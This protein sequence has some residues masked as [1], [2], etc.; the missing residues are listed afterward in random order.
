MRLLNTD[1]LQLAE[2]DSLNVP[3]YAILSHTWGREELL[4]QDFHNL[5]AAIGKPGYTKVQNACTYARKYNFDW[6]WIDSCCINKDSSAELSE[7]INSMYQYYQDAVVC[8]AYLADVE[9][10]EDPRKVGSKFRNCRWFTRGWTL[11]ELLAPSYVVFLDRNWAD[12]G[13]KWSLRHVVSAVTSIPIGVLVGTDMEKASVA[14][15]MSWAATRETTRPEDMAYCLMG[16]FGI[17]MSPIYGEGGPKAFMRLQQEI[18]RYSDDRS[19][20]AW[21]ASLSSSSERTGL[22]ARTPVDFRFSGEVKSLDLGDTGHNSSYSFANNGLHISLPLIPDV[23]NLRNDPEN[24]NGLYLAYLHCQA[25]DGEHLSVHLKKIG[26]H[27]MRY[28]PDH[29]VLTRSSFDSLPMQE[30]VVKEPLPAFRKVSPRSDT[31]KFRVSPSPEDHLLMHIPDPGRNDFNKMSAEFIT[32]KYMQKD[33][34]EEFL[35][36]AG[37]NQL[38]VPVLDIVAP[39]ADTMVHAQEMVRNIDAY[40][41]DR[42]T[43]PVKGGGLVL[44]T[45]TRTGDSAGVLELRFISKQNASMFDTTIMATRSSLQFPAVG[46][47]VPSSL[48]LRPPDG[49]WTRYWMQKIGGVNVTLAP[50]N[51][52]PADCFHIP[53]NRRQSYYVSLTS[54]GVCVLIYDIVH[55]MSLSHHRCAVVLGFSAVNQDVWVDVVALESTE[56]Y[57]DLLRSYVSKM[58]FHRQLQSQRASLIVDFPVS[59]ISEQT[60]SY[61]LS[62]AVERRQTLQLGSHSVHFQW[63]ARDGEG[64]IL[65]R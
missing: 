1:T 53:Y 2:F 49:D 28:R 8:Y 12:I 57:E 25:A 22:F 3:S 62:A 54:T 26:T 14:Q 18:I 9:Y 20:F 48:S 13:T 42:V 32:A 34:G 51:V 50:D 31:V 6:I 11:Q 46:F 60:R 30:V 15:R 4:Y 44:L 65:I 16:I 55:P 23:D 43:S 5:K 19:I 36:L 37:L 38:W 24:R 63:R 58:K 29:L 61:E 27:F 10:G 35:V 39:K 40:K 52:F 33:T 17:S 7:A 47:T 59:A 21:S 64:P 56:S 41:A 45:L